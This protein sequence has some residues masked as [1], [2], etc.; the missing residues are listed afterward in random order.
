M[1]FPTTLPTKDL[2]LGCEV[3][4][5][6]SGAISTSEAYWVRSLAHLLL[7]GSLIA[8]CAAPPQVWDKAGASQNDFAMDQG[9]CQAQAF[10]VPG[11]TALQVALVYNSCMR[12]KGWQQV[13]A[14]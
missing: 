14:K 9:Q 11:G 3:P 10:G 6:K 1:V 4:H 8:G 12:G 5:M 13:P 2:R 7:A